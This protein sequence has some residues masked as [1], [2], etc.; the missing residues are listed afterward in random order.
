MKTEYKNKAVESERVEVKAVGR[1]FYFPEYSITVR[2]TSKEE[3]EQ[4]LK[5]LLN[6][7]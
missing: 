7:S 3:A 1:D 6:N 2:A 5:K 4:K